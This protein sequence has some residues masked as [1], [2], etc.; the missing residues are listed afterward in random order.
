MGVVYRGID[1]NLDRP[2]AIK[3]LTSEGQRNEEAVAC[4]LREAKTASKLQHPGITTIY[5]FGVQNDL[6]YLV[7]ECIEGKTLKENLIHGPLPLRQVLEIAIQIADA[8]IVA[9]EKGVI[10]RDL[11]AEN[12]M[13][14]DRGQ[15]KILD[16]GLAKV[17]EKNEILSDGSFQT[18]DGRVLGTVKYMS[19][20]QALGVEVD[21]RTDIFSAGVVFY[22]MA[23]GV[24]PFSGSSPSVVMAKI[25]NQPYPPLSE[26]NPQVPPSLANAVAKCLEKDRE[27]RYQNASGLLL[28]LRSIRPEIEMLGGGNGSAKESRSKRV[29]AERLQ[30]LLPSSPA[31]AQ[32]L[33]LANAAGN[34]AVG[35]L[36][37]TVDS[38]G[39]AAFRATFAEGRKPISRFSRAWRMSAGL[40]V[41]TIR[42]VI[43]LAASI[44]SMGCIALFCMPFFR[45]EA[46]K[47]GAEMVRWLHLATDPVLI[48]LTSL[49]A[50]RTVFLNFNFLLL[51]IALGVW[52]LQLTLTGPLDWLENQIYKPLKRRASGSSSDISFTTGPIQPQ[53]NRMSLLRDY[54]ASKRLLSE[55][56]KEMAFLAV[57]VVGST[58][59]KLGEDQISIEHAFAEYRKFMDRIF[60]DCRA[61]KV[62]WTPDGAMACFLSVDDAAAAGRKVL[63]ELS[64][65]NQDVHQ[66][67]TEFHVRCGL[68]LGEVL[69][70]DNKPLQE[71]SDEVI[72]IAGHLQKYADPD[73]MWVSVA[74]Y[75]R[76]LHRHG[77]AQVDKRVDD[78]DVF[79]WQ[80]PF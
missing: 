16:F 15:V 10:H 4:F 70:P 24:P 77:F 54:A 79:A 12:I 42:R 47:H 67:R 5:E 48:Y 40:V 65:F 59:M 13:L 23:A 45:P 56:K 11:T 73:T 21:L 57:D 61:H 43:V 28:A 44:Y 20:E 37:R 33:T 32:P 22:E 74:A 3:I 30:D 34:T 50:F 53:E 78:R 36:S 46:L 51:A 69:F 52:I 35:T 1:I 64:W 68:N 72:D 27:R 17:M 55:V 75:T 8:L 6:P 66:L 76:L 71:I 31:P 19:P 39:A 62:A 60:R 41:R 80:K 38:A 29:T 9:G 2:V 58:R 14:T 63:S 25:L 18:L 7:M 49:I 26:Y